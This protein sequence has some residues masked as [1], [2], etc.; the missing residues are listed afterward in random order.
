MMFG[1]V[2]LWG[3]VVALAVWGAGMLFPVSQRARSAEADLTP[4]GILAR[5]YARG[6]LSRD[7]YDTMRS[8]IT[9]GW[10]HRS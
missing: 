6:D 4:L 9:Q 7:Q 10:E 2:L 8:D 1:M 3:G 5:R